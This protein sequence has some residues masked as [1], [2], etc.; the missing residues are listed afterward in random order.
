MNRRIFGRKIF[1]WRNLFCDIRRNGR[2]RSKWSLVFSKGQTECELIGLVKAQV[3]R[4]I[5]FLHL[6]I[7]RHFFLGSLF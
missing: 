1:E 3:K 2:W 7:L 4:R 5:Y 6:M